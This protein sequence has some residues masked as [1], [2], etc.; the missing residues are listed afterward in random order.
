MAEAMRFEFP[1]SGSEE[2]PNG[3][4]MGTE[5]RNRFVKIKDDGTAFRNML[6]V[7]AQRLYQELKK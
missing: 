5:L 3:R 2:K 4:E 7:V 6:R 1:V